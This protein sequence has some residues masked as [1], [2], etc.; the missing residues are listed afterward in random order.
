M[1]EHPHTTCNAISGRLVRWSSTSNRRS[2][3]GWCTSP[4]IILAV[5]DNQL[6]RPK[7]LAYAIGVWG[8]GAICGPIFGPLLGGFTFQAKGWTWPI[9]VLTWLSGGCL[10]FLFAFFPET[11]SR[12]ILYRR[13]MRLRKL[14]GNQELK[15]Q[16]MIDTAHLSAGDL[17]Q[18]YLWRPMVL[19]FEPILLV[20][21]TYLALIYGTSPVS[22]R[23]GTG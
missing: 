11:S 3:H 10:V 15:S 6:F 19:F 8:C 21:N 7:H 22:W 13:V 12:T 4:P 1:A 9:W 5:A 2:D 16:A 23:P 17:A 20:Y 18:E 14:T